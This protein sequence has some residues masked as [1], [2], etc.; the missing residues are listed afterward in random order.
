MYN[1]QGLHRAV[2][3]KVV[4]EARDTLRTDNVVDE[5]MRLAEEHKV[6]DIDEGR[7]TNRNEVA[8][9]LHEELLAIDRRQSLE[10]TGLVH[11]TT[12]VPSRYKTCLLY[13]SDAA[14]ERSSVDLGGRRSIKKKKNKKR[15]RIAI[16]KHIY[17]KK[18][19]ER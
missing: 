4:S 8:G 2:I 16:I 9:W 10:G 15:A 18:R 12:A 14:D 7:V 6:L 5:V 17:I 13:T 19:E 1:G 11:I 3:W